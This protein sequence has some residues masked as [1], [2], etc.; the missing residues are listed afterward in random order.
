ICHANYTRFLAAGTASRSFAA[1]F[2]ALA[3]QVQPIIL[4]RHGFPPWP[5]LPIPLTVRPMQALP[6][7]P[8]YELVKSLGGGPLTQV[9]AARECAT[10]TG[11]AVKVLR[12]D[13]EDQATGLK[14]L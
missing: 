1:A 5:I 12:G 4:A 14:L 10:D 13:W 6:K 9:Y 3:G 7:I 2:A 11:C 8:G